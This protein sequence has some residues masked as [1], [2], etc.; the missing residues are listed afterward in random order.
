MK[1]GHKHSGVILF[2]VN[3]FIFLSFIASFAATTTYE[4]RDDIRRVT[5]KRGTPGS[6][7]TYAL[8]VTT[9]EQ[10]GTEGQATFLRK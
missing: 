8:T 9:S 5:V 3:A 2:I 4:Y 7:Q 10:R 1:S 6:G